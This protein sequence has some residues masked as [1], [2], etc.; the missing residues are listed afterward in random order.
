[1]GVPPPPPSLARSLCHLYLTWISS[2]HGGWERA[3]AGQHQD[4]T[5]CL[6][7]DT[8]V[9]TVMQ[10]HAGFPQDGITGLFLF[11]NHSGPS[12][13]SLLYIRFTCRGNRILH[14]LRMLRMPRMW[15]HRSISTRAFPFFSIPSFQSD[16][17][18]LYRPVTIYTIITSLQL[19]VQYMDLNI[20]IYCNFNPICWPK[21]VAHCFY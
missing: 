9:L 15:H 8:S 11:L 6:F 10:L 5:P 18:I 20:Y 2:H 13:I 19:I 3:A 1:M 14:Y 17:I 7:F 21:C 16:I 12:W 4:L